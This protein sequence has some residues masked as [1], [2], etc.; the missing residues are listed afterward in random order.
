MPQAVTI[1]NL[2]RAFDLVKAMQVQGPEWCED[3]RALGREDS[4][5]PAASDGAGN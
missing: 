2:P 4:R 5:H 3:Y 1:K